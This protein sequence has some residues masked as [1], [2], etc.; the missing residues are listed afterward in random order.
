MKRYL[1]IL[2]FL[3][4]SIETLTAQQAAYIPADGKVWSFGNV[5]FFGDVTNDGTL[6]S[7]PS[8]VLY[9]LGQQWTNGYNALLSDESPSGI[10]GMGGI[11]RFAGIN[12]Q[13]TIAGGYS[14]AAKAGPSFPNLEVSNANG[15]VLADL[16]DLRIRNTLQLTNGHVYLNGWNLMVGYNNPGTISGYSD[17]RF[18][19]TGTETAGG[20]LYRA[21]LSS[22]S[23]KVVFPIGTSATNYAPAGVLYDGNPEDF[24]ARVFDSVYVKAIAGKVIYDSVVFKTWNLG[25]ENSF[26][27]APTN[28]ALQHMD[29]T[30]GEEFKMN[31]LSSYISHFTNDNWELRTS[32]ND[33]MKEGSL[34]THPMQQAAT[35]HSRSFEGIGTNAYFTKLSSMSSYLPADFIYFNAYRV[36]YS[37]VDIVWATSRETN[38]AVFEI[39]RMLDNETSFKKIATVATKA[40]GGYS[41]TRL[42]Y[43]FQDTNDYDGWS[44]YRIKAVSTTGKYVYTDVREVGP[45]ITATV[46]PNP[47]Y[48]QFKVKVRGIKTPLIVQVIDT[49]GQ[50]IRRLEMIGESEVNI[51]DMPTGTYFLVLTHKD[52]GKQAWVSKV[53]VID[54]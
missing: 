44:Y 29:D 3:V 42:D 45:L 18:I 53:I 16:N 34:T 31:R 24:K 30:E 43:Y 35:M 23:G 10:G 40:P 11:F 41:T 48:G 36:S 20:F 13:Q 19:V 5:A 52:S 21:K 7:S 9:F 12:G 17:Q 22:T 38:N 14:L 46:F 8:S 54:H 26:A 33:N 27:I 49:W 6:G 37:L 25:Q 51:R 4:L 1:L 2:C 47:N 32:S 39:E 28:I 50:Q 15:V